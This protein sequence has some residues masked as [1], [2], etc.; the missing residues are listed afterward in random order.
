[1]VGG[2]K[3][4]KQEHQ[5]QQEWK[6]QSRSFLSVPINTGPE[7][8]TLRQRLIESIYRILEDLALPA[9]DGADPDDLQAIA[10]VLQKAEGSKTIV[11]DPRKRQYGWDSPT[12]ITEW[13]AIQ[14]LEYLNLCV[15]YGPAH[16][17][18]ARRGCNSLM[19]SGRGAKKFCSPEC[20]KAEWAYEHNKSYYRKHRLRSRNHQSRKK[21][22]ATPH[23]KAKRLASPPK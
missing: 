18:C 11:F 4:I 14:M 13:L 1:M 8:Q 3:D 15:K 6:R 19:V 10:E 20:R 17:V 5:Y 2:E 21:K 12:T 22:R 9:F 7:P 16:S 23:A